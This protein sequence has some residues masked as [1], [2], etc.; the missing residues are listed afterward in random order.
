MPGLAG[1]GEEFF[2]AAIGAVVAGEAGGEIAAAQE[3]AHGGDGIGAQ[4]SHGGAVVLFIT[5]EEIIPG[6]LDD[7]P[8]GEARGRR[9]W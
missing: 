5:G 9:A 6:M 4:G 2:V 3:G 8:G 7:L 1:E